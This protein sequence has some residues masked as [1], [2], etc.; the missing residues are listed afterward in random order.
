V[1][2]DPADALRK[3]NQSV[4]IGDPG[5]GKTTLLKYL[6]IQSTNKQLNDIPHVPIYVRLNAFASSE[7]SDLLAFIVRIWEKD[8]GISRFEA[9]KYLEE[10][11]A[12]NNV[13]FLLDAL[14]EAAIGDTLEQAE[15]SY[16]LVV[17]EITRL[18]R[19]CPWIVVTA[20]K[21]GYH[22]RTRLHAFTE[23]EILD[24]RQQEIEQFIE[25]WFLYHPRE[26]RRGYAFHLKQEIKNNPRIHMF[27]AN[28]LLLTLIALVF[29]EEMTLPE[30]RSTLYKKCV[31]T[32]LSRWDASRSIR[33]A[34]RFRLEYQKQLL[35]E[36]A[37]RMHMQERRHLTEEEVLS[38]ISNFLSMLGME[39]SQAHNV[40]LELS[41]D[42]GLLRE[43]GDGVY[44]FFHLTLQEYFASQR[45]RDISALLKHLSNPWWEEVILLYAGEASDITPLL[46]HLLTAKGPEEAPE[47]IFLS[48]L[49][50]AGRCLAAH[51][52]IQN[53]SL[54]TEIPDQL[55]KQVLQ[56]DYALTQQHLA[57]TL[58]EIGRAYPE[59]SVNQR[60]L[61]LLTS[62]E[63]KATLRMSIA[64]ALGEYGTHELTFDL[65][66]FFVKA[67]TVLDVGLRDAIGQAITK[68]VDRSLLPLLIELISD[69]HTD[70]LVG[71]A[72]AYFIGSVGDTPS[73]VLLLPLLADRTIHVYVRAALIFSIGLLGDVTTISSLIALFADPACDEVL[74]ISALFALSFRDYR[75][76]IPELLHLLSQEQLNRKVRVQIAS[77]L[78][79][80][81][82]HTTIDSLTPL[83]SAPSFDSEARIACAI[84]LISC[85]IRTQQSPFTLLS[86]DSIDKNIRTRMAFTVAL[87]GNHK[88]LAEMRSLLLQEHNEQVH[89]ALVIALGTL[90]DY[91]V[92]GELQAQ[93]LNE[94]IPDYLHLRVASVIVEYVV[95][96]TVIEILANSRI[97]SHIRVALVQALT[98]ANK[99]ALI[100]DLLNILAN[101]VIDEEVRISVA[102]AIG[103]L[104][105][106]RVSL[107]KLL[108]IWNFYALRDPLHVSILVETIYQALWAVSRRIG[109]TIVRIEAGYRVLEH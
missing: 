104:G 9:Q 35:E 59:R 88:L 78:G 28:P 66:E 84:A 24:F 3:Y 45:V 75:S 86:D 19:L 92:F 89:A 6:T 74:A 57:A 38:I 7:D 13:I 81:G 37:W 29:E 71:I 106:N 109:V 99:S 96:S 49:T 97:Q 63:H 2:L 42:I 10:Q 85:S 15:A 94:R 4:I 52:T 61:E 33:R 47:D 58:A 34:R 11:I 54:W 108:E 21:A 70:P 46:E 79:I 103:V 60:L 43:Q 41:G 5:A 68:L 23:L 80:I 31:D 48:K 73:A 30:R 65:L 77:T 69:R 95:A 36:I 1:A 101:P 26:E 83:V 102:E 76:A 40:L 82:D 51:P 72:V 44:G 53:V 14:D 32:L 8:Y 17:D 12:A 64:T 50:L 98:V 39:T 55:F 18:S 22:Q 16:K 93:F 100:P 90:G 25:N 67:G 87:L 27:V 56:T 105:E 62:A 91:S 20:R 107:E